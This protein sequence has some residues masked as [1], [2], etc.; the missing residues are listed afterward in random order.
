MSRRMKESQ[1]FAFP[2][3]MAPEAS[4]TAYPSGKPPAKAGKKMPVK[5]KRMRD[6]A[7]KGEEP[8]GEAG[9]SEP[10]QLTPSQVCPQAYACIGRHR[11]APAQLCSLS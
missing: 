7:S 3:N 4:G 1:D 5:G 11:S 2:E 9:T 10:A 6:G 8:A